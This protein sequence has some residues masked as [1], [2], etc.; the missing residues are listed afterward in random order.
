MYNAENRRT[1]LTIFKWNEK[2]IIEG[3]L[4]QKELWD[5]HSV[6]FEDILIKLDESEWS[7]LLKEDLKGLSNNV[8]VNDEKKLLTA[9][10][11]ESE[12]DR[13]AEEVMKIIWKNKSEKLNNYIND[14]KKLSKLIQNVSYKVLILWILKVLDS[15]WFDTSKYSDRLKDVYDKTWEIIYHVLKD[16]TLTTFLM[17]LHSYW[18]IKLSWNIVNKHEIEEE[19]KICNIWWN[20]NDIIKRLKNLW[21]KKTFE[22][23]IED[24]Y[25]DYDNK[26]NNLR[27]KL[28]DSTYK[29]TFRIR[30]KIPK[31]WWSPKYYY[32]I[33]RK[34]TDDEQK[35]F[36][37]FAVERKVET[38][39]CFEQEFE[40]VDFDLFRNA[41]TSAWFTETRK[42]KKDRVSYAIESD[43]AFWWWTK[44]DI[45]K[46][47]WKQEMME[48]EASESTSITKCLETL[49]L[50]DESKYPRMATGSTKFLDNKL[51]D[52]PKKV[53]N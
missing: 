48:I 8:L 34:L 51:T 10:K 35:M 24:T 32:T 45:D 41:I 26:N 37:R 40:I 17:V 38:R 33:K 50:D 43:K 47:D 49:W 13:V 7:T 42:K 6:I 5:I 46:Y 15:I 29:S 31:W 9:E 4:W 19:V 3:F 25:Y 27:T 20:K 16:P 52:E 53:I 21:A 22:W 23:E 39:T 30:K 11:I 44:F 14:N 28:W 18:F 12:I 2:K 36:E 1:W